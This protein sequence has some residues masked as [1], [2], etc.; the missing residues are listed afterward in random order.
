MSSARKWQFRSGNGAL[1]QNAVAEAKQLGWPPA[2]IG[3]H[4]TGF[5]DQFLLLDQPAKILLVHEPAG[6]RLDAAL[7]LKQGETRRH[8]FEDDGAIFDLGA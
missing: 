5:L 6:Q 4:R 7:K 3:R 1:G 2:S 8:Q